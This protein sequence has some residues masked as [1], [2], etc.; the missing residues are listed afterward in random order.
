MVLHLIRSRKIYNNTLLKHAINGAVPF[1]LH[2][3][4]Q[5]CFSQHCKLESSDCNEVTFCAVQ[6]YTTKTCVCAYIQRC[7]GYTAYTD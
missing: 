1:S 2:L 4:A 7:I 6:R 3:M 5:M